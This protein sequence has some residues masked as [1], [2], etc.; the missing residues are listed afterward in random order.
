MFEIVYYTV[1]RKVGK[2]VGC[3]CVSVFKSHKSM[4]EKQI[5]ETKQKLNETRCVDSVKV[6]C[7]I[8]SS[9]YNV[10]FKLYF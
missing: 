10:K 6:S 7:F 5:K 1:V 2:N 9:H 8:H 4:E 3:N